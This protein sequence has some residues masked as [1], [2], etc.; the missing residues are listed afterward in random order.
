MDFSLTEEQKTLQRQ[1]HEFAVRELEPVALENEAKEEFPM[2]NFRKLAQLGM[3]GAT[4]PEEYG[5][6][7]LDKVSYA[8]AIEEISRAC[9]STGGIFSTQNS[10]V[11]EDIN[12]FA[13]EEQKKQYLVPLAKGE[14]IGAVA[15]TES[16]AGSDAAA[17]AGPNRMA[18]IRQLGQEMPLDEIVPLMGDVDIVL[19]EGFKYDNRYKF[20]RKDGIVIDANLN[21]ATI[22]DTDGEYL[23]TIC[24][25]DRITD[26]REES[27]ANDALEK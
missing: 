23:R 10:L 16:E 18:I 19:T 12:H 15:L 24:M 22:T 26:L 11:C 17:I 1:I 21:A 3:A 27:E 25:I 9:P 5:G 7:G 8:I 6:S 2:E 13:S 4:I 20:I 14:K